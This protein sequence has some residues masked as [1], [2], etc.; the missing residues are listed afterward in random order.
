MRKWSTDIEVTVEGVSDARIVRRIEQTVRELA[1]WACQPGEW[2]VL[3]V[4]SETRGEW[5]LGVRGPRGHHFA[6]FRADP[7]DLPHLVDGQLRVVLAAV[8]MVDSRG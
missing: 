4:P 7:G 2:R 8:P 6:S 3:V 5:D 1:H